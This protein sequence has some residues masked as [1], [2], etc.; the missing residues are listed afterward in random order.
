MKIAWYLLPVFWMATTVAGAEWTA[1]AFDRTAIHLTAG[2]QELMDLDLQAQGP[3]FSRGAPTQLAQVQDGVRTYEEDI[4]FSIRGGP[5]KKVKL[6][7]TAKATGADTVEI[8]ANSADVARLVV[9]SLAAMPAGAVATAENA[10]GKSFEF[11]LSVAPTENLIDDAAAQA[12][13]GTGAAAPVKTTKQDGIVKLTLLARSARSVTLKFAQPVTVAQDGTRLAVEL[14][15]ANRVTA[16]FAGGVM[17]QAGNQLVDM[18]RWFQFKSNGDYAAPSEIGM[19]DWLDKPAGK[20]GRLLE[21]GD[22]MVFEDGTVGKFWGVNLVNSQVDKEL[23]DKWARRLTKYGANLVRFHAFGKPNTPGWAHL[24]K[25]AKAD[26]GLEFD[27]ERMDLF[28]YGFAKMKENGIYSSWSVIYG[29]YP[30]AA[31]KK[32]LIAYDELIKILR[33]DFPCGGSFY[34]VTS[35]APDVEDLIIQFHVKLLNHVNPYTGVRYADE[36]A[37]AFVELQNEECTF[38]QIHGLQKVIDQCPTYKKLLNDRFAAWLKEKYGSQEALAKAWGG[39]LKKN[40]SLAQANITPFPPRFEKPTKRIADQMAFHYRQQV[41]NF[42][43][44]EKAVR[45]TGYKGSLC[46]SNWHG[47]E[48]LGHV[49][50]LRSDAAI[51]AIDRHTYGAADISGPGK[52]LLDKSYAAVMGRPFRLTEWHG[53]GGYGQSLDDPLVAVYGLGLQGRDMSNAFAW[54]HPEILN[55]LGT[56]GVNEGCDEFHGIAQWPALA[57]MLYR[58][59]VKEGDVAGIR[60]VSLPRLDE[61][62]ETGFAEPHSPFRASDPKP[63]AV[64]REAVG[65]GRI[66]L[67]FVNGPVEQVAID[68]SGPFIDRAKGI[69]RSNTGQL[70]WHTGPKGYFTVNTPGT[71]AVIGDGGG[72]THQLGEVTIALDSPF[73]MLYVTSLDRDRGVADAKRL[74]VTALART[75]D[76]GTVIDDISGGVL[77]KPKGA[78]GPLLIEPVKAT[79]TLKGSKSLRVTALDH[80]GR[81]VT[82]GSAIPVTASAG[83]AQFQ[84]DGEKSR[85]VYY[86]IERP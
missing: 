30:T 35:L 51:G 32:R 69:A 12:A 26:D 43:K 41:D 50:N 56:K 17:F 36:P 80:D 6:S 38:L 29:W 16:Q 39:E 4:P 52:G 82:G 40:E 76:K 77:V 83:G 5:A 44:F 42:R 84:I 48:W 71:K 14:G 53:R 23:F 61:T 46:G 75:L 10:G 24:L 63:Y 20:H 25:V 9:Q 18:G 54:M 65:V 68:R 27:P 21:K 3:R 62:G 79:I 7:Y 73:A 72:R 2:N 64:P 37:L 86:L 70:E 81:Q 19:A 45:A 57:R 33:T 66:L 11:P 15:I 1:A 67:E 78:V 59:D 85:T 47:A 49:Q 58:G 28:D 60:R 31:D 34:C 55:H 22:Q 74:L 13:G 8:I